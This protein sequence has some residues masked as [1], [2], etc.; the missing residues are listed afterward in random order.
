VYETSQAVFENAA[1]A[2]DLAAPISSPRRPPKNVM[3]A[4][5][6][7]DG[8]TIG[9]VELLNKP[10]DFTDDDC[11]L[12]T[13]FGNLVAIAL[14]NSRNIKALRDGEARYRSLFEAM[15][16]AVVVLDAQSRRYIDVNPAATK[17]YGYTRE[18]FF[19]LSQTEISAEPEA[20]KET[21]QIILRGEHVDVPLRLHRKKNGSVFPVETRASAFSFG[22]RVLVFSINRDITERVKA[23]DALR[24]SE[25]KY[26]VLVEAADDAI[27]LV[28][29]NGNY[30]YRNRACYTSLG[31]D[32]DDPES[33]LGLDAVHPD[34]LERVHKA[35][36]EL[37]SSGLATTEYRARHKDGRW[38]HRSAKLALVRDGAG[39][40]T[41]ALAIVRDVTERK[42]YEERLRNSEARLR[43]FFD[44]AQIGMFVTRLDGSQI[45]D[46]NE[47][48]ARM[49]GLMREEVL[50]RPSASY[51]ADMAER[52][53]MVRRV[54]LMGEVVDFECRV[55]ANGGEVRH[56]LMSVTL[57]R[58]QGILE[59]SMLDITSRKRAEEQVAGIFHMTPAL[60]CMVRADGTLEKVNREWTRVLG[61]SEAE[62][63]SMG[64]ENLIHPDDLE[65]TH[66]EI[67]R[68]FQGEPRTFTNRYRCKDG[69]YRSFEWNAT[70]VPDGMLCA[71]GT[72]IT[73]RKRTEEERARLEEQLQHARKM[74]AIGTLAGGVAHDFNNI[75][76]GVL[77]GL[78]VLEAELGERADSYKNDI[79]DMIVLVRR[80]ADLAKQL[81]GIGRRGRYDVRPLDLADVVTETS[82]MF[83][84]TRRDIA[85]GCEFPPQLHA[86]LMDRAQLE[87]V[88]FNLFLN[89]GQAMPEGGQLTITA[90]ESWLTE[91]QASSQG[92]KAGNFVRF[93]VADTGVGMD[94]AIQARI[95]EPFFTT[96]TKGQSSGLGLASVYGIIRNHGG[97]I[98][99]ASEP[100]KGAAFTILL[101]ATDMPV[102]AKVLP[103]AVARASTGTILVVDDEEQLLRFSARLLRTMGYDVLTASGGREAIEMVREQGDLFSLVILDLTMPDLSGAETYDAIREVAPELKVLL[104]SGFT[105]EGQAQELL[106]RGCNDFIQ[107]PFDVATLSAKL[108]TLLG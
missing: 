107:K 62:I 58:E 37:V 35:K 8:R 43:K 4:P 60:L 26:R 80:G 93:V 54:T 44:H 48:L 86:V 17:L 73:E 106:A 25:A 46:I 108:R 94:S 34:D 20:S 51:W 53:E 15:T 47:A 14:R 66:A 57:D 95:F 16:D 5:L 3:V 85:I 18:E 9:V 30:L 78:S 23:E 22:D 83:G 6:N 50:A 98:T 52:A 84:R 70:P 27:A 101:P 64:Y 11:Q 36:A 90:D 81:L 55:L 88:L 100:G 69:T 32:P 71:C 74:E 72:D 45:L 12:A 1:E 87:Q 33:L 28:D 39:V 92:V 7:V 13:A 59:G 82:A 75:L 79:A 41:S 56:G 2:S 97:I 31:L 103:G 104:A 89:A 21:L 61:Y 24:E 42:A 38:I 40:P 10:A 76:C 63:I 91:A 29:L 96:K 77:T 65:A 67:A 99:V 19:G 105:V 49:L 102:V 68:P